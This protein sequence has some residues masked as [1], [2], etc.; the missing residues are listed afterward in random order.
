MGHKWNLCIRLAL[1]A[2]PEG[3]H[4]K[5]A[6]A[7]TAKRIKKNYGE[8]ILVRNPEGETPNH[9]NRCCC[10]WQPSANLTIWRGQSYSWKDSNKRS[11]SRGRFSTNSKHGGIIE[12]LWYWALTVLLNMYIM[13]INDKKPNCKCTATLR[14]SRWCWLY[15]AWR[16]G[17]APRTMGSTRPSEP[18]G[19]YKN[20]VRSYERTSRMNCSA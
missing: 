10:C 1:R 11:T 6:S 13:T 17:M 12:I 16:R 19:R 14:K 5:K 3:E 2:R 18:P 8:H 7:Q 9:K 4:R 15:D 20:A